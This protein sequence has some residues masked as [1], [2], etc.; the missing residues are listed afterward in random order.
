MLNQL[1]NLIN[2]FQIL[3][4]IRSD[5]SC[6][7]SYGKKRAIKTYIANFMI[8]GMLKGT[9]LILYLYLDC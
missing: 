7:G 3:F 8:V 9:N 6:H 5:M 2:I 1:C 4:S